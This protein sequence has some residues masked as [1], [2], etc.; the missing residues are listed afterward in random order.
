VGSRS[1]PQV[2][3]GGE[4]A[5]A[6]AAASC[7]EACTGFAGAVQS[8]SEAAP[9][10]TGPEEKRWEDVD[11][12]FLASL[13]RQRSNALGSGEEAAKAAATGHSGPTVRALARELADTLGRASGAAERAPPPVAE[14]DAPPPPPQR[15]LPPPLPPAAAAADATPLRRSLSLAERA[16]RVREEFVAT[17]RSYV[18][19]L[20]ALCDGYLTPLFEGARAERLGALTPEDASVI[21]SI[22]HSLLRLHGEFLTELEARGPEPDTMEKFAAFFKCYSQY[23]TGHAAAHR[24]LE[25]HAR[26]P[27]LREFLQWK[28]VELGQDIA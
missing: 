16:A 25:A 23:V 14:S 26:N 4:V 13:P 19:S 27:K 12:E 18:A 6:A 3:G 1:E 20:R 10:A 8:G 21:A 9:H 22:A 2:G 24:V 7:D 5:A 17:E 28:Q 11:G 15:R